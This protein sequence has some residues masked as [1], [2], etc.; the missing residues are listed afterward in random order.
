MPTAIPARPCRLAIIKTVS[1][2]LPLNTLRDAL[3]AAHLPCTVAAL[4][5]DGVKV[6]HGK[7]IDRKTVEAFL[8]GFLAGFAA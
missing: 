1:P 3:H 7:G 5:R 6:T 4:G 8:N 2:A